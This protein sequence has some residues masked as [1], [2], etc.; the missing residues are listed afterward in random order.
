[1]VQL[2]SPHGTNV[3]SPPCLS[4]GLSVTLVSP[5]QTAWPIKMPFSLWIQV[6]DSGGPK[7]ACIRWGPD[8]LCEG[9]ITEEN[10][11]LGHARWHSAMSYATRTE[12]DHCL[13]TIDGP[14]IGGVPFLGGRGAQSHLTQCRLGQG[15]PPYQVAS[16]SISP[17][18]HNRIGPK[19]GGGLCPLFGGAGSPSNRKSPGPRPT[20]IS[21]GI[22]IHPAIWPQWTWAKNWGVPLL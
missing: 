3:P 20:T 9:A 15:L 13:A 8:P 22:L 1:M 12:M 10:N 6:V 2:F 5:A 4:V 21:S 18:G 11:M 19:T 14:K 17:F 7:K 16:W